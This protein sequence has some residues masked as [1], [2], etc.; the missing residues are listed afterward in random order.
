MA[1]HDDVTSRTPTGGT[2]PRT[3]TPRTATP[4]TARLINDR[5]AFDLLLDRGPLTRTELRELTG[6]SRPTIAELIDRLTAAGL[7]T[8]V[9]EAGAQRRGPNAVL[10]GVAADRAQVAGVEVRPGSV[11]AALADVTG[12]P[13]GHAEHPLDPAASPDAQ[14]LRVLAAAG[15]DQRLGAVVVGTP[16]LIDPDTGDVAYVAQ[17]PGWHHNLLPGLRD[18]LGV[19]VRVDNEV[20]LVGLAEHRHGAARGRDSFALLSVDRGLGVAVLLGGRLY[21]G[22]S[23]GAGEIGYLPIGATGNLAELVGGEAIVDLAHR[24]GVAGDDPAAVVGAA[25]DDGRDPFLDELADRITVAAAGLCAVLDPGF[26]V[27]AGP[28]GMAGGS[29]LADRVGHRLSA[30]VPLDTEVR[31]GTVT[32]EPVLRGAVGTALDLLHQATFQP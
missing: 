25:L 7:V 23:G 27:L 3:A 16:G 28:V 26:L 18:R 2:I 24:Y 11:I 10:Y 15:A 17:M 30:R 21:R 12:T 6:L 29:A 22:A 14:V 1:R 9:G 32:G 4:R 31:P 8:V 20:N 13:I 19:P 5:A